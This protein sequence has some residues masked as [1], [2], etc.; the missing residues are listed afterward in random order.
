M[1]ASQCLELLALCN[2]VPDYCDQVEVALAG[3]EP[4]RGER[5]EQVQ[6]KQLRVEVSLDRSRQL[7]QRVEC[8]R[9]IGVAH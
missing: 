2:V 1:E 8:I 7:L 6:A 3:V 9:Q 5:A 4:A